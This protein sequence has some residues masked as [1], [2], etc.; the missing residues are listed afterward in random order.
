MNIDRQILGF[1]L[2][3]G[4]MAG[5]TQ[6]TIAPI[7]RSK[8][9]TAIA[10]NLP[11][12]IATNST[13]CNLTK[14][15]AG[16]TIALKCLIPGGTDPHVYQVTAADRLALENA[17][18]ILYGGYDFEHD[19]V[20]IIES[21]KSSKIDKVAVFEKAV[22]QPQTFEE[23]GKSTKDPHIFHDAKNGVKI[24]TEIKLSLSKILPERSSEYANNAQKVRAELTQLDTW[25]KVQI[26]TIPPA[27]KTLVTTHDALGYYAKAYGIPLAAVEGVSTEE[28]PTAAKIKAVIDRIRKS[29]VP[30]IFTELNVNPQV[31]RTVA[32][33][34]NVKIS[35]S[36]IF[37]D[38]LGAPDSEASTYQKMLI[39]NTK[40]I[41]TGLGG[42]YTPF[43]AN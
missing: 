26:A 29:Q 31:M 10:T 40:S 30:T 28:K 12:V 19:L 21:N 3:L 41:V 17:N 5:C 1:V 42:K 37:A 38:G 32:N 20:K 16:E 23:D 7:E 33:D 36:A 6:T 13:I 9:P 27:N 11:K 39:A 15:V 18:L 34:A 4:M 22:P 25:I 2:S 43:S 35:A 24:V 14:Q 8:S